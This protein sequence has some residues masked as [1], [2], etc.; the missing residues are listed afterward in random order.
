MT[1]IEIWYV[2]NTNKCYDMIKQILFELFSLITDFV[3][4]IPLAFV[5]GES[6]Y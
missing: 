5:K 3:M 4:H 1:Y 2:F 6:F